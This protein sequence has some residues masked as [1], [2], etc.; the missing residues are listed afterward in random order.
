MRMPTC[1]YVI[2]DITVEKD[3]TMVWDE[4]TDEATIEAV[5]AA[6]RDAGYTASETILKKFFV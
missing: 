3:G 5:K 6:L 1:A 2:S 4:R